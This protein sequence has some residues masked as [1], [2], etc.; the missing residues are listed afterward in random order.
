MLHSRNT[1]F[2]LKKIVK[3]GYCGNER[4]G[5]VRDRIDVRWDSLFIITFDSRFDFTFK[6]ARLIH[7]LNKTMQLKIAAVTGERVKL[8]NQNASPKFQS[9]NR[10]RE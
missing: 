9:K 7:S 6:R 1:L 8:R 4:F 2:W 5:L 3:K 10:T